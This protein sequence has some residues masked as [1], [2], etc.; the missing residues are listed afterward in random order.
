M[1]R[2]RNLPTING[3]N[4]ANTIIRVGT[5]AETINALNGDDVV[6]AGGGGDMVDG[7][8]G[9]DLLYGEAGDDILLGGAG[10]DGLHGGEDNDYLDGGAGI[11][12]AIFSG[13][14]A[15]TVDLTAGTAVGQGTDTLVN[16]ER[17]MGSSFDDLIKG[18]ALANRLEGGDG[19]DTFI[20]TTGADEI[21]GGAGI[22]TLSYAGV[23]AGVKAQLGA[24]SIIGTAANGTIQGVE[25]LIGSNFADRLVGDA[26]A[27]RLDGG[28]GDDTLMGNAGD[29]TLV[30]NG[31]RDT[32]NGGDG[33]DT[34]VMTTAATS[35]TV[36]DFGANGYADRIDLSDFGFD[37]NGHSTYW[38]ASGAQSGANYVLTLTGLM[39]EVSTLTLTGV[40]AS[41]LTAASFIGAPAMFLPTPP[42]YNPA[43]FGVADDFLIIP[44]AGT[45]LV[46]NGF[47]DGLDRLD[48]AAM[49]FDQ[50]FESPDWFGYPMQD[51]ADTVLRFW[52][53]SGDLYE[54]VLTGFDIA[55]LDMTDFIL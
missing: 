53:H 54:V 43:G 35:A 52:D 36:A 22:D 4:S 41:A 2:G 25:N 7:G 48:L 21:V 18:N 16:I 33:A 14:A 20:A 44:Q 24:G 47:E 15:V 28:L 50:N 17:V 12:W 3:T 5:V 29:D 27:N 26:F 8:N 42:P 46:I 23:T 37:S 34:F 11:D 10:N 13:G 40:N 45:R 55:N 32:L 1:F 39:G 51:G 31:G 38:T 49:N 30:A 19:N 9:H 6:Y